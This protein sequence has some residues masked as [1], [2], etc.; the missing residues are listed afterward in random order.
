MKNAHETKTDTMVG[1]INLITKL[2]PYMLLSG[3]GV[4][5][6]FATLQE[7]LPVIELSRHFAVLSW[8]STD[9]LTDRGQLTYVLIFL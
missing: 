9:L 6:G 1:T 3:I 7:A 8:Q 4:F 2:S 5:G